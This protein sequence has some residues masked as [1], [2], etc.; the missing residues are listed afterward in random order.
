ML[1]YALIMVGY[2]LLNRL[3]AIAFMMA[4]FILYLGYSIFESVCIIRYTRAAE[5]E[6]PR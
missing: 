6:S 5:A 1:L 4:F 2:S 3:D